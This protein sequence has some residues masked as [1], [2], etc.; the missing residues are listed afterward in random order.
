ML[1]AMWA[2]G[3]RQHVRYAIMAAK[4]TAAPAAQKT[5]KVSAKATPKH[6]PEVARANAA[7]A[8]P[9]KAQKTGTAK[10][11]P[12]ARKWKDEQKIVVTAKGK[13]KGNPR[14]TQEGDNS[15]PANWGNSPWGRLEAIYASKTVGEALK[16][17]AWSGTI[18]RAVKDGLVE[19]R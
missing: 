5:A 12:F 17:G 7:K 16:K 8:K 14:R 15:K 3:Q 6:E 19:V 2:T 11:V 10:A 13:E 9:A 18:S 1:L 4:K